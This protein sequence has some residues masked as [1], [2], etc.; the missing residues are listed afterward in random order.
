MNII[1]S[2]SGQNITEDIFKEVTDSINKV[3]KSNLTIDEVKSIVNHQFLKLSQAIENKQ[4]IK[5]DYWC[6]FLIKERKKEKKCLG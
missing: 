3:N 1:N 2:F 4:E 6:K 5:L